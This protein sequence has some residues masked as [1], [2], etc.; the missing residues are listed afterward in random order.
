MFRFWTG[1]DTDASI[2]IDD[3]GF[4]YVASEFQRFNDTARHNGQLM[5][6]NPSKPADP[7]AWSIP[8]MEIGF[9]GA[10]GSWSTPAIY[11]EYVYFTTA[12]GRV[13]EVDR[14]TAGSPG[15]CRSARRRSAPRWS[16]TAP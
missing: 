5:K 7:I 13:L 6:L 14:A 4:L 2:V 10:G 3:K 9:E 12:A 8:A 1:D 15:R 11:G 16:W